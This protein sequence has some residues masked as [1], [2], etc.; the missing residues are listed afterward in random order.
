[1]LTYLESIFLEYMYDV[2]AWKCYQGEVNLHAYCYSIDLAPY[3][4]KKGTH[5]ICCTM[6]KFLKTH[7]SCIF[8]C[9]FLLF[10]KI[11]RTTTQKP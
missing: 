3:A 7:L 6:S 10:L 9:I 2:S 1:M 5:C 8:S 11:P 4:R